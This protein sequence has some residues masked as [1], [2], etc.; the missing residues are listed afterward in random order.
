MRP[1]EGD[2]SPDHRVQRHQRPSG[3]NCRTGRYLR[4]HGMFET[5]L[6]QLQKYRINLY[7]FPGCEYRARNGEIGTRQGF[8]IETRFGSSGK[9]EYQ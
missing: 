8:K 9:F 4:E 6:K 3:A 7:F 2:P 5:C 1:V